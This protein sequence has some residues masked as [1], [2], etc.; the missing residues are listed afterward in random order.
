M[1]LNEYEKIDRE[2]LIHPMTHLAK[3]ERGEI[4]NRM[5]A[6]SGVEITDAQGNSF[7]DAFSDCIV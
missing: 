3:F 7:I 2:Y 1:N 6:A 4:D 5:K